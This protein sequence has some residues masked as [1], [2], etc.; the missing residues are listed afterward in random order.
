MSSDPWNDPEYKPGLRPMNPLVIPVTPELKDDLSVAGFGITKDA[1]LAQGICIQCRQPA[2]EKC[3]SDAG[4]R[5]YRISG[6][7]ELCF[8]EMFG[9]E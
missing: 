9:G 5:E 6:M 7:C 3:Y 4:R 2:E 8:D 1:A